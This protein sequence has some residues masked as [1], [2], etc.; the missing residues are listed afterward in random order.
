MKSTKADTLAI[1][2]AS[3]AATKALAVL[4]VGINCILL[5]TAGSYYVISI[6]AIVL[7]LA[8]AAVTS[9]NTHG[10]GREDIPTERTLG[11]TKGILA[12]N[13]ALL[14][15]LTMGALSLV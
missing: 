3:T 12:A 9:L 6:P 8:I 10:N 5:L 1:A 7:A 15:L 14:C 11:E 4:V 13:A 2:M